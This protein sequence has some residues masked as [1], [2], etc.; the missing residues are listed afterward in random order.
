MHADAKRALARS[1]AVF[2]GFQLFE[3]LPGTGEHLFAL[4]GQVNTAAGPDEH[5]YS[6][7]TFQLLDFPAHG[8]LGQAQR[9][10]SLGEAA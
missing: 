4:R 3:D 8:A 2:Q 7:M 6:E 10:R 5:R 9:L 1:D